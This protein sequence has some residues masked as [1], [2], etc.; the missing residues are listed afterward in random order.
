MTRI[1]RG[2]QLHRLGIVQ[3]ACRTAFV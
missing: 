3:L 1:G 2:H